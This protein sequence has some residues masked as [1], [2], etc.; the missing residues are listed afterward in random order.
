MIKLTPRLE[1]CAQMCPKAGRAVD[2]GCDHGYL[3]IRLIQDGK[4]VTTSDYLVG[5]KG[6]PFRTAYKITGEIVA[7]CIKNHK[8]LESMT[9]EEYKAISPVF[10]ADIYEAISMKTC[11]DKRT[12]I[13]APSKESMEKV[14]KIYENYL[15]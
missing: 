8:T 3:I 6:M 5:E 1:L 12:T 4:A 11:V 10:E 2:I 9:L 14:I 7:Y 15:H 13:G